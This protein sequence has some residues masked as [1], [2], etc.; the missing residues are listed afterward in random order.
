MVL[1]LLLRGLQ[2][3]LNTFLRFCQRY[4]GPLSTLPSSIIRSSPRVTSVA[5]L[6]SQI[7]GPANFRKYN[8]DLDEVPKDKG[9][10]LKRIALCNGDYCMPTRFGTSFVFVYCYCCYLTGHVAR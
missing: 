2:C 1:L 8:Y 9:A 10:V 5:P 3:G 7:A 4:A 6:T